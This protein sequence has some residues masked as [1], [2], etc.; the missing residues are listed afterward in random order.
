MRA[1]GAELTVVLL[2]GSRQTAEQLARDVEGIDMIVVGVPVGL[3][4]TRL[5]AP[6]AR[7]G[8]D[9]GGRARRTGPDG[10]ARPPADRARGRGRV[11]TRRRVDRS[12]RRTRR[13]A[14]SRGS[15][16]ASPSFAP[17]RAPTRPSSRAS[18]RSARPSPRSSSSRSAIT[19]AVAVTVEQAKISCKQA[20]DRGRRQRP[21]VRLRRLGRD[22][23]PAPLRR[24]QG[25]G[26]RRRASRAT[27]AASSARRATARGR[28]LGQATRHATRVRDAGRAPTSSSTSAASAATS[29]AFA[30]PAGPRWSRTWGCSR[31]SAS[32]AT[33]PAARTSTTPEKRG[34]P[35]AIR[36]D[37][38]VEVCLQCHTPEH[39][40]TFDYAAYMRDIGSGARARERAALGAGPTGTSC[41]RRGWRRRAAD[42]RRCEPCARSWEVATLTLPGGHASL[43]PP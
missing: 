34:K 31:S 37:P 13:T 22:P 14:S 7:I 6:S 41:G 33:A 3:E 5:G 11:P 27:S 9:V 29:P 38:G 26:L 10:H 24:R 20:A 17:T 19:G 18:S 12:S 32:S 15:T 43:P 25:A 35:F 30:S 8:S 42:A 36:R 2:Q 28:A 21:S 4:R 16:P 1:A 39:S 40:D 23:E